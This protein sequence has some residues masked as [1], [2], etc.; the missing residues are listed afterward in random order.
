MERR[1]VPVLFITIAWVRYLKASTRVSY[2][3]P[4]LAN[5]TDSVSIGYGAML[6]GV[7][8]WRLLALVAPIHHR[9]GLCFRV[10][11]LAARRHLF[12]TN[13]WRAPSS[14]RS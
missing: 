2:F 10:Y 11:M 1:P 9:T 13:G 12:N 4:S 3:M 6:I 8:V 7:F 14:W 5:E